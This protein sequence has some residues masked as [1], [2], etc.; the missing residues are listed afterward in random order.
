MACK[1]ENSVSKDAK[2]TA[3]GSLGDT[4]VILKN[5]TFWILMLWYL[6]QE[7]LI[8]TYQGSFYTM[9]NYYGNNIKN[10]VSTYTDVYS[11]FQVGSLFWALLTGLM[12]D[13]L[14]AGKTKQD[15]EGCFVVPFFLTV[16]TGFLVSIACI[17]P[18]VELQFVAILFHSLLKTGTHALHLTFMTSAFPKEHFGKALGTQLSIVYIFT[19]IEL[20]VFSWYK[21]SLESD[22]LWLGVLFLG[23]CFTA[24][25]LPFYLLWRRCRT[26][27]SDNYTPQ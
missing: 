14:V 13:K 4:L 7:T 20:P 16:L 25:C 21:H 5:P 27:K 17:I 23:L 24:N 6:C 10:K 22:P 8:I 3:S 19:F 15:K 2:S 11:W 26:T 12:L 18:I 9:I 1:G